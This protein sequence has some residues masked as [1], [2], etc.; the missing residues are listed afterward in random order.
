MVDLLYTQLAQI[1]FVDL[2]QL[3]W[4]QISSHNSPL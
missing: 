2:L 1:Y 3:S 4:D